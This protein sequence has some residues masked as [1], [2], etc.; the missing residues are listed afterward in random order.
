MNR[1]RIGGAKKTTPNNRLP[2]PENTPSPNKTMG[3]K[4]SLNGRIIHLKLGG[5][6]FSGAWKLDVGA[7]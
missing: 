3:A 1:S 4:H 2:A 5:W 7:F 6:N